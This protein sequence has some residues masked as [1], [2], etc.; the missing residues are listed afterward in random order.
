MRIKTKYHKM[1]DLD[2]MQI[3]SMKHDKTIRQQAA[4]GDPV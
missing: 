1:T 4:Q 2:S 3:K